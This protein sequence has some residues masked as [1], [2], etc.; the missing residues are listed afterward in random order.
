MKYQLNREN[1]EAIRNGKMEKY[2][3]NWHTTK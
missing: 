2:K 3:I 1:K